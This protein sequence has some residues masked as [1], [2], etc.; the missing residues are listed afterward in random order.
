MEFIP[1]ASKYNLPF[2][3]TNC[4]NHDLLDLSDFC[5]FYQSWKSFNLKNHGSDIYA[6]KLEEIIRKAFTGRST[7]PCQ[8]NA[9][10]CHLTER[11]KILRLFCILLQKN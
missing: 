3:G 4:L 10:P 11:R 2:A 9:N 5:D 8:M 7:N 1:N 6:A